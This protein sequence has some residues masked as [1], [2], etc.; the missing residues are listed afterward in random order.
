MR[1]ENAKR[2]QYNVMTSGRSDLRNP[3]WGASHNRVY[4]SDG[5]RFHHSD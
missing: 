3:V 5:E 1:A 2:K 4:D